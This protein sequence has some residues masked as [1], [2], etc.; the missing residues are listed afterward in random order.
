MAGAG[1]CC[2]CWTIG[3]YSIVGDYICAV[4]YMGCFDVLR[5]NSMF[6]GKFYIRVTAKRRMETVKCKPCAFFALKRNMRGNIQDNAAGQ[7]PPCLRHRLEHRAAG[8]SVYEFYAILSSKMKK[9]RDYEG[10]GFCFQYFT[11]CFFWHI[12]WMQWKRGKASRGLAGR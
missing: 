3:K 11:M 9:G 8:R 7:T 1:I 12:L 2:I 5:E 6:G 4:K 10:M